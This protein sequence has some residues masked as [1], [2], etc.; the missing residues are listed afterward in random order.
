MRS[1]MYARSEEDIAAAKYEKWLSQ[2]DSLPIPPSVQPLQEKEAQKTIALLADYVGLY[3]ASV[4]HTPFLFCDTV[5]VLSTHLNRHHTHEVKAVIQI[6]YQPDFSNTS[7]IALALEEASFANVGDILLDLKR[8]IGDK[9]INPLG[10][11]AAILKV[12]NDKT[13]QDYFKIQAEQC[14]PESA[15]Y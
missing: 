9:K 8:Q 7:N 3:I 14:V 6:Y 2:W 11:L 12:I 10:D 5:R 1:S 13:G 15:P 4:I